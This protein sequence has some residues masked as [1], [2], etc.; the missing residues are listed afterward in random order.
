[1][2]VKLLYNGKEDSFKSK[3]SESEFYKALAIK[4]CKIEAPAIIDVQTDKGNAQYE[5]VLAE[6]GATFIKENMNAIHIAPDIYETAYLEML[7]EK[8]N[9]YEYYELKPAFNKV[10]AHYGRI[11][12]TGANEV[13]AKFSRANQVNKRSSIFIRN[14]NKNFGGNDHSYPTRMYWIKFYEK[15]EKGYEDYSAIHREQDSDDAVS[16]GGTIILTKDNSDSVE[17][18]NMLKDNA[19][20]T[21]AQTLQAD[22][23]LTP[24]MLSESKKVLGELNMNSQDIF[25]FN[26][27][28]KHLMLI[29]PRNVVKVS[30]AMA[31]TKEDINDI[32]TREAGFIMAMESLMDGSFVKDSEGDYFKNEHIFVEG[33]SSS[34][35]QRIIN[36][37]YAPANS[38]PFDILKIYSI[39]HEFQ[40]AKFEEHVKAKKIS[41][42]RKLWHGSDDETWLSIIEN[43]LQLCYANPSGMF[44]AGL[45]FASCA[46]KSMGYCRGG[47]FLGIY[48]VAYGNP[49]MLDSCDYSL[50]YMTMKDSGFNCVHGMAG[51][52]LRNDEIITYDEASNVI[53]YL[54][55]FR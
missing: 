29:C 36:S 4:I 16:I 37:L 26:Q 55:R 13:A 11:N 8:S 23:K 30:E 42:I 6:S 3:D 41:D 43:G 22:I 46:Q 10:T 2:E 18:Y 40:L 27:E 20:E 51:V 33:L 32:I 39:E 14:N 19:S 38:S 47:K 31:K 48:D 17:L 5:Q 9:R 50:N 28:L 25:K 7:D 34:D 44:G 53:K 21:V 35:N 1:M 24:S 12:T 54:V 49:K 52:N 15:I 45:Y